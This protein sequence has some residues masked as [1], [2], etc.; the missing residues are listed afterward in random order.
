LEFAAAT[1]AGMPRLVFLLSEET[2]GPVALTRDLRFGD[3]Q[4][5]FRQRLCESG[6]T[7]VS[8]SSPDDLKAAVLHA[9]TTLPRPRSGDVP[10]GRVWNVPPRLVGF[11]G[12]DGLLAGLRAALTGKGRVAVQAV[13]GMGGVG[14]TTTAIEYAHRYGGDYD[15]VWW[16]R[17]EDPALV[18]DQLT[19]LAQALNLPGTAVVTR[20]LGVLAARDRWLMVFD[21]AEDPRE[22][23]AFL[24][25]V[26]G[27]GHVLVTSRNPDWHGFADGIGVAQFDRSESVR[28][29]HDRVPAL[30]PEQADRVAAAVGDL[31]LAVGQAAGMLAHAGLSV[32]AYLTLLSSEADRVMEQPAPGPYPVS[33]TASWTVAFDRLAADHAAAMH[34]V[35]L[36][37][38]LAPE[39]V[40]L[41]L[42]AARPDLLPPPLA[43][44]VADPLD[45]SAAVTVLRRRGMVQVTADGVLLHRVPAALLRTRTAHDRPTGDSWAA[46]VVRLLRAVLPA[47]PWNNPAVWPAW[48]QL[49]PHALAVVDPDRRLDPVADQVNWLLYGLRALF[50]SR[51]DARSALPIARRAYERNRNRLGDDHLI[52]LRSANNLALDLS[53]AGDVTAARKLDEDTLARR[54]RILGD[55]HPETLGS[56]G[57]LA[58]DL[59]EL[60]ETAAAGQLNADTLARRRRVLGEDH[61]DTLISASNVAFDLRELGQVA[62]ARELDEDTLARRRRILGD[63]HPDTLASA[64]S[65][66]LDLRTMGEVAAARELDEDTLARRRRVLGE[67]HPDALASASNVAFDLY[68][69]GE[70][71]A[72]R[73]LDEDTL[74]R[75]RRVLGEDHPDTRRIADRLVRSRSTARET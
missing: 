34:L 7:T 74:A 1:E 50:T 58:A 36:L 51:G 46:L 9:L 19:A 31:P 29:L 15:V 26:A 14:K 68:E 3:R 21:N 37:A 30:S 38:W 10:A 73:E 47:D 5:A 17:A 70:V 64:A 8:V 65:L 18:P 61:P 27:G 16:V 52:T 56:A 49:L 35:T 69:L 44:V 57:N 55:D 60:G 45:L 22:L 4:E 54:R 39:P 62:A 48:H 12:R 33:V 25:S 42:L 41:T 71:A 67:D 11:T 6:L 40:P 53:A 66:A 75:R 24:P 43:G 59:Y 63:D 23:A 28:L 13:H 2:E 72:A 20:V 32:D